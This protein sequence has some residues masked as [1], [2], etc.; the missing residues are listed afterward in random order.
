MKVLVSSAASQQNTKDLGGPVQPPRGGGL[1]MGD[2]G[3]GKERGE[4]EGGQGCKG[5]LGGSAGVVF[6]NPR[7][8]PRDQWA[9]D[10]KQWQPLYSHHI[11]MGG[12]GWLARAVVV[13]VQL[14]CWARF[15][16]GSL[17]Q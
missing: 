5:S 6:S 9:G 14:L 2:R 13:G 4:G 15:K 7:R 12:S 17:C 1:G 8:H 3:E 11:M 16:L 10:S